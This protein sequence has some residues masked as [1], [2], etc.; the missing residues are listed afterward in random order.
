MQTYKGRHVKTIVSGMT[1]RTLLKLTSQDE[2]IA[3]IDAGNRT[4]TLRYCTRDGV[5]TG[6]AVVTLRPH[7]TYGHDPIVEIIER[8]LPA[9]FSD[10][11]L[12]AA[13][14]RCLIDFEESRQ[15]KAKR[16]AVYQTVTA[17]ALPFDKLSAI[18]Q[19]GAVAG[20]NDVYSA[21][22][23]RDTDYWMKV[24]RDVQVRQEMG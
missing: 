8:R 12:I 14:G 17:L 3:H 24:F 1:A 9:G 6:G 10:N 5:R 7:K 16:E 23:E 20:Y 18:Q 2:H 22:Q 11:R 19:A 15:I 4:V 13:I 21:M